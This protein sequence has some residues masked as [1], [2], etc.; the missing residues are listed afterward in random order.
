[1]L[2]TTSHNVRSLLSQARRASS[3]IHLS[4]LRG[5]FDRAL[6]AAR[7]SEP[8]RESALREFDRIAPKDLPR[9]KKRVR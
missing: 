9:K 8:L 1:M 5:K 7:L 6:G 3:R 2:T 4:L